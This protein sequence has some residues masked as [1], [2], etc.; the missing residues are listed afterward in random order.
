KYPHIEN[1]T[2]SVVKIRYRDAG[3]NATIFNCEPELKISFH[4][5][6]KGI[7]PGQ[8]AVFY[9]GDDVLAGGI[10][11]RNNEGQHIK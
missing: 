8:S 4:G 5:Q 9:E 2:E 10:I 3:T 6:A 1:G 7:A 11:L